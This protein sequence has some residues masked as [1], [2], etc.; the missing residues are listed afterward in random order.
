MKRFIAI[1]TVLL[2]MV[3]FTSCGINREKETGL[4]EMT[5]E[6]Q[7]A[8]TTA[9]PAI[10]PE[11]SWQWK[12]DTPETH[13]I[14]TS[15]LD[16]F[17][18]RLDGTKVYA[19]VIIKDDFIVDEYYKDGYNENSVF[20]LQSCSKSITSTLIGIAIDQGFIDGTEVPISQY[21]PQ[22]E[23]YENKNLKNITIW[24]LLTH[25]SG[26]D[27]SDS[28]IWNSWRASDNWI[29]YALARPSVS[30]PGE[31]FAYSTA[32]THLLAAILE[33]ATGMSAYDF[34][35]QYLFDPMGITSVKCETA[36]EGTSDGGNGFAMNVYDMAKLGKLY[37]DGGKWQQKQLVSEQWVKEATTLQFKRSTGSADYGYQWW[38]RTF[39][40]EDYDAFF[41]QGHAGQYIFVVP[42]IQL[43]VVFTSNHQGSSSMYWQFV[44]NIVNHCS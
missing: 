17:H 4:T 35:K 10:L 13:N 1:L 6:E 2:L 37:L 5:Q 29:E 33:K 41:A 30:A 11:I 12:K 27:I 40:E 39:G 3:N 44:N 32:G 25:T 8:D 36:P 28:A 24:H 31:A 21:F 20:T 38:V 34:G 7:D 26:L 16:D 18:S 43:I 23:Q 22:I 42:E 15:F 14:D 9:Q 19:S